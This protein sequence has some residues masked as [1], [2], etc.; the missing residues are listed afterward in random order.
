MS[1]RAEVAGK[2]IATRISAGTM[3][4]AISTVVLS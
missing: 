3:V 2:A 1:T 4:Q